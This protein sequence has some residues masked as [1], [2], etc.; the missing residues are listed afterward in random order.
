MFSDLQPAVYCL[1][2]KI[3]SGKSTVSRNLAVSKGAV[4]FNL[5]EIMEPLFGQTLGRE[6]YVVNLGICR[7]YLYRLADRV[8][9]LGHSVVFDFGFWSRDDRRQTI[10]RF[11]DHRVEFVYCPVSD[12]EQLRRV[13]R[14]NESSDKTYAFSSEQLA[15]LNRFFE[16]PDPDEGILLTRIQNG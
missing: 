2:G 16:E 13:Y 11:P 1:C 15:F 14:R 10:E 4:V 6:R 8:L 12:E 3:G 7:D 5:D 9:E